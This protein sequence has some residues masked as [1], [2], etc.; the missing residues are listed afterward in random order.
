MEDLLPGQPTD[1]PAPVDTII[2]QNGLLFNQ[3]K[4]YF[5]GFAHIP[6]S[7]A[8]GISAKRKVISAEFRRTADFHLTITLVID[9]FNEDDSH[10]LTTHLESETDPRKRQ[11]LQEQ[12]RPYSYERTTRESWI[13]PATGSTRTAEGLPVTEENT[14]GA[15]AELAWFQSLN[16]EKLALMGIDVTGMSYELIDFV[17]TIALVQQMDVRGQL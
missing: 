14:P 7:D 16:A 1:P 11:R 10:F 2:E 9:Y 5:C 6:I 4:G 12:F 8:P 17:V 15:I 3:T 13:D